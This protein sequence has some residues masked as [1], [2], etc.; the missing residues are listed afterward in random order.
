MAS[1]L[2]ILAVIMIFIGLV[3]MAVSDLLFEQA[4]RA[5]KVPA[6]DSRQTPF[7]QSA[8]PLQ[9]NPSQRA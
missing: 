2:P 4:E 3:L 7:F 8:E 5:S 1:K 6:E 9:T